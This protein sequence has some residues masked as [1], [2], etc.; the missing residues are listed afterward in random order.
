MEILKVNDWLNRT[1]KEQYFFLRQTNRQNVCRIKDH[2][3]FCLGQ[4]VTRNNIPLFIYCW[5]EDMIN[6]GLEND[7]YSF[8]ANINTIN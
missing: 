1:S 4:K 8:Y 5:H 3:H 7:Q 6:V 2:V